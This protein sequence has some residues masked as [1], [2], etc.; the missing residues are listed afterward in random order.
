MDSF[1]SLFQKHVFFSNLGF[2][3]LLFRPP[4]AGLQNVLEC[5]L[6]P[7]IR[8]EYQQA[9]NGYRKQICDRLKALALNMREGPRTSF[10]QM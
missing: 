10:F 5:H 3:K 4:H 1:T 8:R 2:T 6:E 9:L 7:T